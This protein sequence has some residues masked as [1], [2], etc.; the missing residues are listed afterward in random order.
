M[1]VQELFKFHVSSGL[2]IKV[3]K[4]LFLKKRSINIKVF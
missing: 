2:N 3:N 4:I 1:A